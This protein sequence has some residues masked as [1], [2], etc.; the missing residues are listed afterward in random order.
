MIE[1]KE[2]FRSE[3]VISQICGEADVVCHLIFSSYIL[4]VE[5][6]ARKHIYQP[7]VDCTFNVKETSRK[8]NVL[9][10]N[11]YFPVVAPAAACIGAAPVGPGEFRPEP[12]DH[13]VGDLHQGGEAEADAEAE[14]AADLR[15]KHLLSHIVFQLKYVAH[16]YRPVRQIPPQS[17]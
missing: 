2:N 14:E 3:N 16:T 5:I 13:P 8:G 9:V 17:S 4:F 6:S 15:G 12:D 1:G 11:C 7:S 10:K